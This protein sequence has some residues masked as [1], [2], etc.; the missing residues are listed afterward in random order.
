MERAIDF[1]IQK[2]KVMQVV[3]REDKCSHRL[4]RIYFSRYKYDN[5][6]YEV[7]AFFCILLLS[8]AT[9]SSSSTS[10]STTTTTTIKR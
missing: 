9:T 2:S 3:S 1:P 6:S 7:Y 8:T 4:Y 5:T 10:T